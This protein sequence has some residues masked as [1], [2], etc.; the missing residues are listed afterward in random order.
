[1]DTSKDY[2]DKNILLQLTREQRLQIYKEEKERIKPEQKWLSDK[3]KRIIIILYIIGLVTAYFGKTFIEL[4]KTGQWN[5]KPNSEIILQL[6]NSVFLLFMPLIA[7]FATVFIIY[8]PIMMVS[9]LIFDFDLTGYLM[10]IFHL[11]DE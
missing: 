7:G 10:K 2:S 6:L 4:F 8:M 1:M 11:D 5:Y 9:L 3:N